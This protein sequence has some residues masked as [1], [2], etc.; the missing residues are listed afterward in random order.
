MKL[1]SFNSTYRTFTKRDTLGLQSLS[2]SIQATI[3]PIINVVTP[4]PFYWAFLIWNYYHF[5]SLPENKNVSDGVFSDEFVKRNDFYFVL[6][7]YLGG[8]S[9]DGIAGQN[10]I[11]RD[12]YNKKEEE[13]FA[14][15]NGYYRSHF[16]GMQ[17]YNYGCIKTGFVNEDV[18]KIDLDSDSLGAILTK[19]FDSAIQDTAIYKDYISQ[20]KLLDNVKKE[21]LIE[22][23]KYLSLKM[24][25][26]DEVKE[27]LYEAFF[28]KV[29]NNGAENLLASVE[30]YI[31][32]LIEHEFID[33]NGSLDT[34]T[35]KRL[36]YGDTNPIIVGKTELN[37]R[38]LAQTIR[39]E[40]VIANQYYVSCIEM[41]WQYLLSILFVPTTK[42]EWIDNAIN[43]SNNISLDSPLTSI[44]RVLT[45]DEMEAAVKNNLGKNTLASVLSVLM[46]IYNRFNNDKQEKIEKF[47]YLPGWDKKELCVFSLVTKIK[48]GDFKNVREL[49]E[50][51][52]KVHVI[53]SHERVGIEKRY[54]GRDG[55][56]FE[57]F[58]GLYRNKGITI[59]ISEPPLRIVNVFSVLK[60]LGKL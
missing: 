42:E 14:Y 16:G 6:S 4:H 48:H 45:F 50:Y 10:N 55:F 29:D 58:D 25:G 24:E 39:W 17:Y 51:L 37:K 44:T 22:L 9:L 27:L 35:A 33:K 23:S 46:S 59:D 52:L 30:E 1:P 13:T 20:N 41:L 2:S 26:M 31:N 28:K 12:Y 47:E 49:F 21:D 43:G 8:K 60:E 19:A 5:Y 36:L 54:Q 3:C 57:K 40:L 7:T 38:Q 56:L 32:L 11:R 18:K 53:E 34:A 15:N